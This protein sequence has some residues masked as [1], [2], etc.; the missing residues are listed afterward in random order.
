M[1]RLPFDIAEFPM[2]S[3]CAYP[4]CATILLGHGHCL[5]HEL[6]VEETEPIALLARGIAGEDDSCLTHDAARPVAPAQ[7]AR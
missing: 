7:H 5:A 1:A 6:P 4:G 3:I 2:L